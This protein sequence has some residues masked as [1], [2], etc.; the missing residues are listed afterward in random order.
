MVVG[1]RTVTVAVQCRTRSPC[2]SDNL[3]ARNAVT[4]DYDFTRPSLQ[5]QSIREGSDCTRAG[6]ESLRGM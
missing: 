1:R 6:S 4:Y 5:C 3:A 2:G